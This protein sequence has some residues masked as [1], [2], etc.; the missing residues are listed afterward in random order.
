MQCAVFTPW[1]LL[2]H[3][4]PSLQLPTNIIQFTVYTAHC[5]MKIVYCTLCTLYC[6][7]Y[8]TRCKLYTVNCTLY[9]AHCTISCTFCT[10]HYLIQTALHSKSFFILS[11]RTRIPC[12]WNTVLESMACYA[13][14]L[15]AMRSRPRKKKFIEELIF[16]FI[17]Y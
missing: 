1:P 6:T 3:L 4:P 14:K 11:E 13:G 15:L 2:S 17:K 8:T 5:T 16:T 9:T 12:A 7:L 10:I